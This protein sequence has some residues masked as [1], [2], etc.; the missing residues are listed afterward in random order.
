MGRVILDQTS[1]VVLIRWV[2]A[3]ML[4]HF[5]IGYSAIRQALLDLDDSTL[6]IDDLKE[7]G[8]QLPTTDEVRKYLI[9]SLTFT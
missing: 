1:G 5:K 3:I 6:S 9:T 7:I 8:K 4:S 2:A